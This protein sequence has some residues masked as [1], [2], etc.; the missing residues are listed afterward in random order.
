MTGPI[1]VTFR[2]P[3]HKFGVLD[4]PSAAK[5]N[6]SKRKKWSV[7]MAA[8]KLEEMGEGEFGAWFAS[9]KKKDDAAD[10]YLQALADIQALKRGKKRRRGK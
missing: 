6:Y 7:N 8:R 9:L 1:P 5:V 10:A 4:S 3:R 2:Q